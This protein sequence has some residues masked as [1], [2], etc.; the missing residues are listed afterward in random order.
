MFHVKHISVQSCQNEKLLAYAKLLQQYNQRINLLSRR[1]IE[2]GFEDHIQE[3]L[4]FASL[5]LSEH[6]SIVDWGT[7]GG[8]PAIPLAIMCPDVKIYAVDAVEKKILAVKAFK[9]ALDLPNV[10]PWHGRAEKF[11]VPIHCSVSRAT[12][13][14]VNLWAWHSR[15]AHPDGVLYCMKGGDVTEER[16]ALKV[17]YPL[18]EITEMPLK[19]RER[20]V[21]RVKLP[22]VEHC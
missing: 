6:D 5:D 18:T 21:L 13:S 20:A 14:L 16:K 22:S 7:G 9:R 12:T 19:E 1:T 4:I 3:C 15:V 8:L 2:S 10:H 11:D 17:K